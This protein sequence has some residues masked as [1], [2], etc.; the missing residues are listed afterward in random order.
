MNV[1][2]FVSTVSLIVQVVVFALL[3][4][5]YSFKLR[6]KYRFHGFTM[7][8]AV[9]LHLVMIGV[10]M[11]PAFVAIILEQPSNLIVSFSPIHAVAGLT[12]AVL[13][14]WIVGTWRLRQSTNFCA[15]KK[16]YMLFTFILWLSTLSLGIILYF[17]LNWS[18]F[19][20]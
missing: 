6:L 2:F 8:S 12:T 9:V 10:V 18:F 16:K 7:F 3:M 4:I 19:F 13:G 5:G 1:Y 17:V 15:P 14:I 20:S 11:V